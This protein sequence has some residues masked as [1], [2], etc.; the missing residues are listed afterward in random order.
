MRFDLVN[1]ALTDKAISDS[2]FRVLYLILNNCN[3]KNTESI[4]MYNAFLMDKL[5]YSESTVKRCTKGL[6]EQGYISVKRAT[7]KKTPNIITLMPIMDECKDEAKND[8]LNKNIKENK[9]YNI[10]SNIQT[11]AAAQS[12]EIEDNSIDYDVYCEQ[13]LAKEKAMRDALPK[14]INAATETQ[15][16]TN[17]NF[18]SDVQHSPM[19]GKSNNIDW[20]GWREEFERC[21]TKLIKVKCKTDFDLYTMKIQKSLN[22]AKE[23]MRAEKYDKVLATYQNWFAASEPYFYYSKQN[24]QNSTA[25]PIKKYDE[26]TWDSYKCNLEYVPEERIETARTMLQYLRDCGENPKQFITDLKNRYGIVL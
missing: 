24:R 21:K 26:S 7:K 18:N 22:Y 20:D 13:Q 10:Q 19:Q 8:T 17:P 9:E 1:K 14:N 4:E 23:H 3:M 25:T 6:E 5:C 12:N 2:Q 16:K 15:M 11:I